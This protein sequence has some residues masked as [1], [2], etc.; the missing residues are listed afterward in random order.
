MEKIGKDSQCPRG[1]L[2][3]M[4]VIRLILVVATTATLA[5]T[6]WAESNF[7][8]VPLPRAVTIELPRN[9]IVLS[10]NQ[11]ITLDAYVEALTERTYGSRTEFPTELPF[12]AN[13]IN[14]RRETIGIVNVRY[15]PSLEATQTDVRALSTA[16]IEAVD[17]AW[18]R[19]LMS[20]PVT[21]VSWEGT[22]AKEINGLA[23]LV[24]QYRRKSMRGSGTFRVRL[25]RVLN[26]DKSFTLTV[27]YREAE[28]IF[29][30]VITDRIVNSVRQ[31]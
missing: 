11:R 4:R 18:H 28:E 5:G 16:E 26:G 21:V 9:W 8:T 12:A 17:N 14:D 2:M 3:L 31:R 29:L 15:Y 19:G 13:F 23:T 1:N 22:A 10:A 27:S 25:V 24:T 6:V 7:L 20:S 30:E